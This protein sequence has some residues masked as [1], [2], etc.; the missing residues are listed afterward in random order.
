M[1]SNF[2][3]LKQLYN[4]FDPFRPLPA[5]DPAYVDCTDVRG[6][7]D[8]LEAV[9]REILYSD[10]KTCQLYAGHR[11]AGKS[12]ELLRLQ[13]DLDEKGFFVV[14]FAADEA[15]IDPE[16][17]Q[18]TDILLACTRNILTA[19][20][21]RTDSQAVLNWLK[22]R[23]EDLK[24]LLQTKISIDELS[25]EAQV[26]QFA[27]IT[28]K[29]RSEPSERRKIRDLI[30]PHTTTLTKALNQFIQDAKKNL[31]SQYHE[32]VLIADNLDRIVPVTKADNRS[33][34]DEIF[35]DRNEQLKDLDCHLVYT[36]PI[37]LLYSDRAAS[38]TE[39]YGLPQVLPMI[40]VRTPENEP[41]QPGLDKVIEILQKRLNTVDASKSI[42]D[43]F[44]SRS[45]LEMLCLMSGGHARNLLLLMKEA[46]K[47]TTSLP[48]TNKALQRSFSELRK[49]YKDTIYANEWE[50]LANVHYSKEIVNDQLHRGLLFNR[51][52]LEYRYLESDGGSNVWYDIHPLIKGIKTFQDAY[53]QLYPG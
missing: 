48:I 24:D 17:V 20:K 43:F 1:T 45:S 36:I 29:I 9:G 49:T 19:F 31:P 3:F 10:R 39:I 8:I 46:L 42:V 47:Y 18:Y 50:A 28:T 12:T 40:M 51:C 5:G 38:L 30:N 25:I 44:E 33:N 35:I 4:A 41:F 13:K 15:D 34:H 11:G 27:K 53:N 6:D 7:G 2:A 26:S 52:I 23:C 14:Y 22:E 32:L 21:D 16:D 37:S